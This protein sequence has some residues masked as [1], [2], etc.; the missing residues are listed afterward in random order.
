M[1]TTII[2]LSFLFVL[3]NYSNAQT[4][5]AI[6][7]REEATTKIKIAKEQKGLTFKQIADEIGRDEV[8]TASAL[9]GQN[10]M[11]AEEAAKT[12]TLLGL[13]ADVERALQEYATRGT[14]QPMPPTDPLVYRFYEIIMIYGPTLQAVIQE[15]FGEG[16]MSAIDYS[17]KVERVPNPAGDRVRVTMEGKFLSYKKW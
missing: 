10:T 6:I 9:L 16:I 5:T 2:L 8:W 13:G 12:C 1:K 7:T 15:N 17:M 3:V 14:T 4:T 11:S